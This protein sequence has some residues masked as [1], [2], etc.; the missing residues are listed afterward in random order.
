MPAYMGST[1]ASS[2]C[3][4]GDELPDNGQRSMQYLLHVTC[5]TVRRVVWLVTT[6]GG[7]HCTSQVFLFRLDAWC[8]KSTFIPWTCR[9]ICKDGSW[10]RKIPRHSGKPW[11]F[12]AV[13]VTK[14]TSLT[15]WLDLWHSLGGAV[16]SFTILMTVSG[17]QADATAKSFVRHTG[18]CT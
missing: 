17:R 1:L 8:R 15:M 14:L 5:N 16:V 13:C 9:W 18:P 3:L 2:K 7:T 11:Q 4:K 6:W 10:S 12:S